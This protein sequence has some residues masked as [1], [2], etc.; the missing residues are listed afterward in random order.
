MS[1]H[2]PLDVQSVSDVRNGIARPVPDV[3]GRLT[4][5]LDPLS[6]LL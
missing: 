4:D 2:T 6:Q 1:L 3:L 5:L